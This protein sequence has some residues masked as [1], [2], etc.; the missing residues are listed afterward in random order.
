[1]GMKKVRNVVAKHARN[2]NKSAVFI[3]RK[4]DAKKGK[5]KHKKS[6]TNW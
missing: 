2:F 4:K 3:D 6:L 1:M 5:I